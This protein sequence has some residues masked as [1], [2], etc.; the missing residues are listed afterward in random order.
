MYYLRILANQHN[1]V[2]GEDSLYCE[3]YD[4][5]HHSRQPAVI[6]GI[7]L[8]GNDLGGRRLFLY[9]NNQCLMSGVKGSYISPAVMQSGILHRIVLDFPAGHTYV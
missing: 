2:A 9:G 7:V 1:L 4:C 3:N 6:E 8:P 5:A